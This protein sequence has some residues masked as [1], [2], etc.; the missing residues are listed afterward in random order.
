MPNYFTNIYDKLY[1]Q[2][3]VDKKKLF[4]EEENLAQLIIYSGLLRLSAD[5]RCNF[6]IYP[7]NGGKKHLTF[8]YRELFDKNLLLSTKEILAENLSYEEKKNVNENIEAKLELLRNKLQKYLE[9]DPEYEIKIARLLVQAAH[10]A[11]IANLIHDNVK[12]FVSVSQNISDLLDV[13]MWQDSRNSQGL[14]STSYKDFGIFVSMNGNPFFNPK[15]SENKNDGFA[16]ISRLI[17]VAAQEIAHYSDVIKDENGNIYGRFSSRIDLTKP[18][19]ECQKYRLEAI[20]KCKNIEQKL[21]KLKIKKLLN[22]EQNFKIQKKYKTFSLR[23]LF[24]FIWLK[25][26]KLIFKIKLFFAGIDFWKNFKN[27]Q[28]LAEE[29]LICLGDMHFNL[30]P[31][32]D[33]YQ[34]ANKNIEAAIACAEALAR[35][36][37]QERKWGINI[38]KYFSKNLQKYYYEKAIAAE[39]KRYEIINGKKFLMPKTKYKKPILEMMV[40]K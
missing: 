15:E 37:Q 36:P 29:I 7:V 19:P 34:N 5:E 27:K 8:S 9:I 2:P 24:L 4:V 39:I 40:G 1:I 21:N 17:V 22:I 12:I 32:A 35:I 13:K 25:T 33:V 10:P 16:A 30:E 11:V 26:S 20:E 14:Q 18:N 6:V 23:I 31:K 3:Q 28:Y 38:V